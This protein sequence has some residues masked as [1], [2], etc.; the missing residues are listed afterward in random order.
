MFKVEKKDG[1]LQEY[2][3]SKVINSMVTAGAS[4]EEAAKVLPEVEAWAEAM[5][6][7]GVIKSVDIR[8]EVIKELRTVN[9][10]AASVFEKFSKPQA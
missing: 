7:N 6:E 10:E 4:H 2:D 1:T 5:A 8:L 3:Q 9:P